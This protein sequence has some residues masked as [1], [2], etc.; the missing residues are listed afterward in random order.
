MSLTKILSLWCDK[1]T[2][3]HRRKLVTFIW[4]QKYRFISISVVIRFLLI[5]GF[6]KSNGFILRAFIRKVPLL[7]TTVAFANCSPLIRGS[8]M[9]NCLWD[10]FE[11]N[12]VGSPKA[13]FFGRIRISGDVNLPL[14]NTG[15]FFIFL[16][17]CNGLKDLFIQEEGKW[18]AWENFHLKFDRWNN[19]KHSRPLVLKGY[20]GW[21]KIKNLPLDNWCRSTFER[22]PKAN[23]FEVIFVVVERF[24]KYGHL[25]ALKHPYTAKTVADLF[26]KEVIRLHGYPH[27]IVSDRDKVFLS[28]FWKELVRLAGTRETSNSTLDEQLKETDVTLEALKE[29]LRIAQEKMKKYADFKR[30]EVEYQG[31][32]F[33]MKIRPYR[34]VSLRKKRNEKLSPK[35]FGPY[36]IIERTRPVAYKLNEAQQDIPYM[37]GNHEWKAIPEEVYGYLKNK[38]GGW[39]CYQ[40]ERA[41]T[42]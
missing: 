12:V 6:L 14:K 41:A 20:G 9:E 10:S 3:K 15:K 27:S 24:S 21:L 7:S 29:H 36:K 23:G 2:L 19:I 40:L 22:L 32:M 26:V 13:V 30:R 18:Q 5:I 17:L 35:F 39:M 42:T 8:L 25:L 38:M 16:L 1:D 34:Q 33:F 4:F 28:N 37:T 31:N 11:K